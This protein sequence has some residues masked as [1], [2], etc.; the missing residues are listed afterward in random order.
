MEKQSKKFFKFCSEYSFIL[1]FI[2]IF[3]VYMYTSNGLT[4]NATMNILRHSA[5]VGIMAIGLG[6]IILTGDIDLSVGSALALV[7]GF[8]V[9][10]FNTTN[11]IIITLLFSLLF[12]ATLGLINGVLVG[13]AKMPAFIATLATMLIYRSLAQYTCKV[14]STDLSGGSNSLYKLSRDAGKYQAFYD[15]GNGKIAGVPIVGIILILVTAIIIYITTCTKYGKSIYA[16]GS[17]AIAAKF[18][19]VK[20]DTT[21]V[22]VYVI[23]GALVGLAAFLWVAMNAS[24]DPATTGN[25]YEMYAI[26]GV[27]LGGVSMAGGKGKILGVLFGAMSYTVIDK[28]IISLKMDSLI[29]D[30]VK[31]IIL[32]VA[33]LIQTLGPKIK[34]EI[35][36]RKLAKQ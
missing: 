29:N 24:V 5:V 30:T 6:L 17:N 22:T 14:I 23:S 19:G 12:G 34:N 18:A 31:G 26:A 7:G 35:R 13:Y 28:I 21:R 9:I 1:I 27:V 32:I 36:A 2:G 4:I 11:S 25:G 3:L 10:V 20:V 15:F 33:I 16:I 8:S